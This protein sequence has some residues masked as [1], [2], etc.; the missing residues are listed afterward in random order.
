MNTDLRRDVPAPIPT[1]A[2]IGLRTPHF[3]EILQTLPDLGWV[4]AHSENFFGDGGQPLYF[5]ERIRAHYPVSLHG[6]GLS[7]GGTDPLDR[8]H[9][10]RLRRL[11]RR[12]DPGLVSEHLS[13]SAVG[14]RHLNELLPLPYTEEALALV[15]RR[16]QQVQDCLGRRIL[17]ENIS[18]Y[19]HCEYSTITEPEFIAELVARSGCGILLD[20][21]NAYVSGHNHGFD[22]RAYLAVLPGDAIGEIHL[23]GYAR[24]GALLIDTHGA[25][26]SDPVWR[27]YRDA[28]ARFGPRPTLIEWDNDIPSLAVLVEE[29]AHAAR[30]ME[31][32]DAVAA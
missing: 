12:I 5:L 28:L 25:P 16:V 23:A 17:V 11:V 24:S 31:E 18:S 29:A 27:L 14:G 3:R 9:L 26:V 1:R 22:P 10:A 4:E 2:G 32:G 7:L 20:V 8:A 15:V 19:L 30:I 13:W 6:V 21:N